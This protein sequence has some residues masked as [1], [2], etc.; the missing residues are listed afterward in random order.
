MTTGGAVLAAD[1]AKWALFNA[2]KIQFAVSDNGSYIEY[3][4]ELGD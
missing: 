2:R 4:F 3:S 1:D